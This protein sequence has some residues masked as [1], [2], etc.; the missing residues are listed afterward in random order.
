MDE[1]Y[2]TGKALL[3]LDRYLPL[4]GITTKTASI[5]E[6]VYFSGDRYI[7]NKDYFLP[8]TSLV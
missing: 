2:A 7:N 3:Y 1:F 4:P 8:I 6:T 5:I